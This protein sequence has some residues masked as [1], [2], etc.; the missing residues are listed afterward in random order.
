MQ[1]PRKFPHFIVIHLPVSHR[2]MVW[3]VTWIATLRLW[4]L[5]EVREPFAEHR[6]DRLEPRVVHLVIGLKTVEV[7]TMLIRALLVGIGLATVI[8]AVGVSLVSLAFAVWVFCMASMFLVSTLAMLVA[9]VSSG[10][11]LSI[12]F[13]VIIM[14]IAIWA[15]VLM[16]GI[17]LGS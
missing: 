17:L 3:Q 13:A 1:T 5:L 2:A 6:P 7:A 12:L 14:L 8:L 16:Y 10:T 9:V 4:L 11:I 15:S